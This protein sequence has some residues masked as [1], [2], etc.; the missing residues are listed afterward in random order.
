MRMGLRELGG[1]K[2]GDLQAELLEQLW[3]ADEPLGLRELTAGLRG[4][5]R[6]YTTVVTVLTRLVARGLVERVGDGRR[7]LYRASAD[8]DQLTARAIEALLDSAQNRRAVLAHLVANSHDPELLA[9]LAR[10]LE[11]AQ[12]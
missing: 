4:R 6:A 3:A 9:E 1:R 7:Y 2:L 8:R 12:P 10:I 5:P 11:E